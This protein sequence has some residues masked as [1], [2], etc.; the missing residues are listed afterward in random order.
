MAVHLFA[1]YF[2]H[3]CRSFLRRIHE[4]MLSAGL[5]R[6]PLHHFRT[7]YRFQWSADSILMCAHERSFLSAYHRSRY[8]HV[9]APALPPA[10]VSAFVPAS[11]SAPASAF[12]PGAVSA[13]VPASAFAPASVFAPV[14]VSAPVPVS[15][16]SPA[17]V[18]APASAPV[19]VSAPVPASVF[20]PAS[21]PVPV[22]ALAPGSAFVPVLVPARIPLLFQPVLPPI[23]APILMLRA[24]S[25][26]AIFH[27]F[28]LSFF[29]FCA[30]LPLL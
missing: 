7:P 1:T 30:V 3:L 13:P 15:A 10:V 20:A 17:S 23:P 4:Y 26:S 22:S 29:S 21:A 27:K 6:I 24:C 18:F 16:L 8:I 12:A 19:P 14:S 2:Q 5:L 11:A 25:Y 9:S 28:V